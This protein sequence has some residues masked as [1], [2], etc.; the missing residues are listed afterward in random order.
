MGDEFKVVMLSNVSRQ[1]LEGTK[2]SA[3]CACACRTR[4]FLEK[5]APSLIASVSTGAFNKTSA[6]GT[7]LAY[8]MV[9]QEGPIGLERTETPD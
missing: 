4:H 5:E 9:P 6:L 8:L 1:E 3:S 7:P 2:P